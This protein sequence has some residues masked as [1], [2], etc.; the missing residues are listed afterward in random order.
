M[1]RRIASLCL[2]AAWCAAPGFS[3]SRLNPAEKRA[4]ELN[5]AVVKV[6]VKYNV[7]G[8]FLVGNETIQFGPATVGA[9]GT[10]F[11]YRPDGYIITNGHV[12]ADAQLKDVQAQDALREKIRAVILTNVVFREFDS[13]QVPRP[14]GTVPQMM[15]AVSLKAYYSTPVLIVTLANNHEYRADT[16][17]YSD[18]IQSGG[19]DVAIIKIAATN[20]PT[21]K[22]G[23]SSSVHV[24]EPITVIGYPGAAS[25]S[26]IGMLS[27]S[28]NMIP[29]VTNGHVSAVKS[30][31]GQESVIQS[32]ATAGHG[33]SGGPAF[34]D[35]NEVIGITTFGSQEESGFNFFVP[36]NTA[37]EY[38]N[39]AGA[40]PEKSIFNNLWADALDT[41][42]LGRCQAAKPK[43]QSVLNIMPS[44]PDALRLMA[45][46]EN[47]INEEGPVGRMMEGSSWALYGIV[48]VIILGA[49]FFVLSRR[50]VAMTPAVVG[51]APQVGGAAARTRPDNLPG[52]LP[53][54]AERT[55]GSVQITAG[56]LSGKRFNVTKS[57]LLIGKDPAKCQI[58][59]T[60]DTISHEHAW[61]VPVD[62]SVV[63]IDRGSTNG[64]YI[65]SVESPRVSK[66]GLQNG[67]R[68]FL[69]KKG[70]VVLTYF[71]S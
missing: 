43:L 56:A 10:G 9:T 59:V 65:N 57:G 29:S 52:V 35:A 50:K 13:R 20:L 51:G 31:I 11:I 18:S 1:M 34:N 38:V 5:P 49:A 64:T 67:D 2:C 62:N 26:S 46:S 16:K 12:V 27:E 61:I 45:A 24:Q 58:V 8:T 55:F 37:M 41:Y 30:L 42:D 23:D 36:I 17:Q 68:V 28:S 22:L 70:S 44:E 4:M 3:A 63:V 6:S 39:T 15:S 33:N 69:G 21:V 48:G 19:K 60:D 14:V 40:K 32:D 66:V 25:S 54:T 53:S 71:S 47:C 7:S